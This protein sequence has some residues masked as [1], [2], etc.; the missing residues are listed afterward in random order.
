MKYFYRN[1]TFIIGAFAIITAATL[2]SLD[3]TL[4]RPNFYEF[5]AINIVFIEH[6]F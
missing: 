1:N 3:G 2:W 5:P 4:I 6:V